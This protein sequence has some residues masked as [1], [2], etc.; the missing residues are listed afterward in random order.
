MSHLYDANAIHL[1]TACH[2]RLTSSWWLIVNI[3]MHSKAGSLSCLQRNF[4]LLPPCADTFCS[5]NYFFFYLISNIIQFET[6]QLV[7]NQYNPN[8]FV[9]HFKCSNTF[10]KL[11]KYLQFNWNMSLHANSFCISTFCVLN[12]VNSRQGLYLNW[13]TLYPITI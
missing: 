3:Y 2:S 12:G 5:L 13:A 10:E 4:H 9:M 1:G 7:S 6:S 8:A 11:D